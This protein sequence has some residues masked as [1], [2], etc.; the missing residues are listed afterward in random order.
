MRSI[1]VAV[2]ATVIL[3]AGPSHGACTK[4]E[5]PAC[6][7]ERGPFPREE[8]FDQCRMQMIGYK[9]NMERYASCL[10]ESEWPTDGLLARTEL[11]TT[12]GQYNR[13]ARGED[14]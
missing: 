1:T 13:R 5:T 12:L 7:L 4:P 11:E 8:D 3:I 9:G 6:A 10:D 2:A 14:G